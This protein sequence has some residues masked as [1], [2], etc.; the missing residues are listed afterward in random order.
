MNLIINTIKLLYD[1]AECRTL[2]L[3]KN[4]P[5]QSGANYNRQSKDKCPELVRSFLIQP[6][7]NGRQT[8]CYYDQ[9][10]VVSYC[11]IGAH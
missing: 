4:N 9:F 2:L 6:D 8:E 5:L 10:R 1:A 11:I 7:K 3:H